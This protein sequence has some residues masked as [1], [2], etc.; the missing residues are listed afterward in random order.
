MTAEQDVVVRADGLRRGFGD[1]E[2]VA[3]MSAARDQFQTD[4][5]AELQREEASLDQLRFNAI[6]AEDEPH[7]ARTR[8]HGMMKKR[9]HDRRDTLD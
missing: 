6:F 2:A 3:R 1:T 5:A 4:V 8:G 7:I 9:K